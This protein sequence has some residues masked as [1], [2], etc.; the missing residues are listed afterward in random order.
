MVQ[1][2][3]LCQS[4]SSTS[5]GGSPTR[6][7]SQWLQPVRQACLQNVENL[8]LRPIIPSNDSGATERVALYDSRITVSLG[9]VGTLSR[10]KW[11]GSG[12]LAKIVL[13]LPIKRSPNKK[14]P[15]IILWRTKLNGKI[16]ASVFNG[17]QLNIKLFCKDPRNIDL[18]DCM[19]QWHI[20]EG[21]VACNC[22]IQEKKYRHSW[23][24]KFWSPISPDYHFPKGPTNFP[25]RTQKI[26]KL[27]R[28]GTYL[29]IY[30]NYSSSIFEMDVFQRA[31]RP[32]KLI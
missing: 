23:I 19:Q 8:S 12:E 18:L 32:W 7:F 3:F 31:W 10:C 22:E 21:R 28:A 9:T 6:F 13:V 4:R 2:F 29:N 27:L 26:L 30:L 25:I 11:V 16:R 15:F 5:D 14:K 17:T 24:G 20:R 1:Y